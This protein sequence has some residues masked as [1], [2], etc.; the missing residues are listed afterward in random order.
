[1]SKFAFLCYIMVYFSYKIIILYGCKQNMN[2]FVMIIKIMDA[3]CFN[4]EKNIALVRR[5]GA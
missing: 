2:N 5:T 3:L 4:N 1:M